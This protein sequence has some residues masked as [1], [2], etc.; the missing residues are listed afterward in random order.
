[1][2]GRPIV[3]SENTVQAANGFAILELNLIRARGKQQPAAFAGPD[4]IL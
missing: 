4:A 2:Y 1:L 3:A